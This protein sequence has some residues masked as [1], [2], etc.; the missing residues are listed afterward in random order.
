MSGCQVFFEKK[1]KKWG[2]EVS[3]CE[4][5]Q[6]AP[7]R[8]YRPLPEIFAFLSLTFVFLFFFFFFFSRSRKKK[9]SQK[10][11]GCVHPLQIEPS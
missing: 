10:W 5:L 6:A 4:R 2:T 11:L 3:V 9:A 1:K 8:I 7:M